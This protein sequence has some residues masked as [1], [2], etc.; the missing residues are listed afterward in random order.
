MQTVAERRPVCGVLVDPGQFL[1]DRDEPQVLPPRRAV[2]RPHLQLVPPRASVVA[3]GRGAL[4]SVAAQ[5]TPIERREV[6]PGAATGQAS[7]RVLPVS[8]VVALAV[9]L[10]VAV[11]MVCV[12]GFNVAN[13]TPRLPLA[14]TAVAGRPYMVQPGDSLWSI[15]RSLQPT[16]D[17][18][19]LVHLLEQ[20]NGV[21]NVDAGSTIVVP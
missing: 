18:R 10:V 21:V 6:A 11:L 4:R 2:G 1:L 5:R 9:A 16:G 12:V 8:L 17:V 15:A 19:M 20:A 7:P 3:S 14:A 13:A